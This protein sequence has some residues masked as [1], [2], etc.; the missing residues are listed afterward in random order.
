MRFDMMTFR[1]S[2]RTSLRVQEAGQGTPGREPGLTRDR[3]E[4]AHHRAR[5]EHP[6]PTL[7]PYA[8]FFIALL[9]TSSALSAVHCI[10]RLER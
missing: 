3:V 8:D 5:R 9:R 2:E 7:G 4:W 10:E 6:C 1:V